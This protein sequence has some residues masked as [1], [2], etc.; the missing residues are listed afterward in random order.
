MSTNPMDQ[1]LERYPPSSD[2]TEVRGSEV[3]NED[4]ATVSPKRLPIDETIDLHG[5][6]AEQATAGLDDFIGRALTDGT[7]KVL[8]VHGKGNHEG[9][10]AALRRLVREY[11]ERHPHVGATGVAP[12]Q[13][14][15]TGATWA[16]VRQRSR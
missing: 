11:L 14:G 1:F 3:S 15:G 8:I 13:H 2:I 12:A 10:S 6:T 4:R 16:I 9:S 5:M 7:R